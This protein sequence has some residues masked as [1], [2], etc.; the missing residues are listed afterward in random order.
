M[1]EDKIVLAL[2]VLPPVLVQQRARQLEDRVPRAGRDHPVGDP[3]AMSVE[4]RLEVLEQEEVAV[5]HIRGNLPSRA[6][7]SSIDPCPPIPDE[8]LQPQQVRHM[9]LHH[10]SAV[11]LLLYKGRKCHVVPVCP[12]RQDDDLPVRK[13]LPYRSNAFAGDRRRALLAGR[14]E[15]PD[16]AGLVRGLG[17][18]GRL[19]GRCCGRL[20]GSDCL[21]ALRCLPGARGLL[22]PLPFQVLLNVGAVFLA[23]FLLHPVAHTQADDLQGFLRRPLQERLQRRIPQ[24]TRSGKLRKRFHAACSV[25]FV[26][27]IVDHALFSC[28][29]PGYCETSPGARSYLWWCR[30]PGMGVWAQ[31]PFFTNLF[32]SV[33]PLFQRYWAQQRFS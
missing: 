3:L 19:P 21:R 24:H 7:Y 30:S 2:P 11:D 31:K 25:K 12:F 8:K 28:I 13:V 4:P 29:I 22:L 23:Q 5:E 17:C 18:C 15:H 6:K 14:P 1:M 27:Q 16:L 20:P 10:L 9:R 33:F 26:F 32:P